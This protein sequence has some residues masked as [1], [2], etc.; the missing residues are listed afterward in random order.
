M[1]PFDYVNSVNYNKPNMMRDTENDT[2]A[3]KGYNPW[4]VNTAFS[5][6]PDTILFANLMN[7]NFH[8]DHR[9]QYE[10]Y[11]YGLRAKTRKAPWAKHEKNED[12]DLICD[13]YECN[14][15]IARD[16]LSLLSFDQ[17][18]AIRKTKNKGGN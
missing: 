15:N 14:R 13:V 7:M 8:L 3:E 1:T 18:E 16:Y 12:L 11:K 10:F 4:V 9:P 5:M 17:L 2:L 6:H